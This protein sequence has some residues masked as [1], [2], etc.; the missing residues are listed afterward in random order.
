[1]EYQLNPSIGDGKYLIRS[2]AYTL[3]GT[4]KIIEIFVKEWL[5]I[6]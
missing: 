4:Q 5:S 6:G 1:M 2:V 3:L